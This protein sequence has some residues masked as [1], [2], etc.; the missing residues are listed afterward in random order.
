MSRCQIN[1]AHLLW[2]G[3]TPQGT[4]RHKK[5]PAPTRAA[6]PTPPRLCACG[7]RATHPFA[8]GKC[9]ACA[10]KTIVNPFV[11]ERTIQVYECSECSD[12]SCAACQ[13]RWA[14]ES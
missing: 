9:P 13:M 3:H 6:T 5:G 14:V 12:D 4:G 8:V 7:A 10:N 1:P 2:M 11:G